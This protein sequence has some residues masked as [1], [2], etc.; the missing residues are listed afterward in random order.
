MKPTIG[1][2]SIV[3]PMPRLLQPTQSDSFLAVADNLLKGAMVLEAAPAC[4]PHALAL[5]CGHSLECILKAY[6][7]GSDD[8]VV[9][10]WL[11]QTAGHDI[12]KL[13]SEAV[14]RGLA[15]ESPMPD[16]VTGLAGLHGPPFILRYARVPNPADRRLSHGLHGIV[17]PVLKGVP[18]H[19]SVMANTVRTH[20]QTAAR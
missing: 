12:E 17:F 11:K 15:I 3:A 19:L 8:P 1:N 4:P 13:W 7:A 6:L 2:F 10:E 16:W 5:L 14:L 18:D 20:L 9:V